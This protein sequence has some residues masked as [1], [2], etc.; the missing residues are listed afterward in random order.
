M[1]ASNRGL[2][3]IQPAADALL[4]I[5]KPRSELAAEGLW[6]EYQRLHAGQ[7]LFVQHAHMPFQVLL[8]G[9]EPFLTAPEVGEISTQP[10][11]PDA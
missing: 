5:R 9:R 3:R 8:V 2:D 1:P 7:H 11:E 6:V 4:E 10:L